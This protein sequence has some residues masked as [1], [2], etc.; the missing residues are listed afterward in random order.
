MTKEKKQ[1]IYHLAI[2]GV[3]TALLCV[4]APF[5]LPIGPVPFTLATMVIYLTVELLGWKWGTASVLAYLLLGLA[6]LPIFSGFA[7]GGGRLFG[8]TG[9]YLVGYIPLALV[10]GW[11]AQATCGMA[12]QGRM[13]FVYG[14]RFLGIVLGT[15]VLY[16]LGTAWYC[17][18]GGV[19]VG[20]ALAKCVIPFLI[21]DLGKM[22]LAL[23]IG[24]P[25]RSGLERAKLL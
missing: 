5:S 25:I 2:C 20:A 11:V 16:L 21:P 4:L 7:G 1:R 8:P 14:F 17:V 18:Q 10:A 23:A 9:G 6:G 15:V 12:K 22:V 19:T 3:M 13:M 24:A